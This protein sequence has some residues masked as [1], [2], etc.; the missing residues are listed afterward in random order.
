M[1]RLNKITKK[2]G[3]KSIFKDFSLEIPDGKITAVVGRSGVGK[4]TLLSIVAGLT[5]FD[6][7]GKSSLRLKWRDGGG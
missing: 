2:W 4:T 7:Q 5:D 1:A 6:R 3:N